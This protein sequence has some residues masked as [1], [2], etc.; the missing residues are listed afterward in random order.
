MRYFCILLLGL[1]STSITKTFAAPSVHALFSRKVEEKADEAG[2]AT[3]NLNKNNNNSIIVTPSINATIL[4]HKG[5]DITSSFQ[6]RIYSP[7][8]LPA[9]N[10][11]TNTTTNNN[12]LSPRNN[13]NYHHHHTRQLPTS[14]PLTTCPPGSTFY[15]S[16]CNP[17]NAHPGSLQAYTIICHSVVPQRDPLTGQP[18]TGGGFIPPQTIASR[19]RDGHCHDDEIC[20]PGLGAGRSRFGRRVATCVRRGLF[21]ELV[22]WSAG[23]GGE[24]SKVGEGVGEGG[25]VVEAGEQGGFGDAVQASMVMSRTDESTPVEVAGFEVDAVETTAEA[26][27]K[28]GVVRKTSRCRDCLELETKRLGPGVEAL[29]VQTTLLTTGAVAGVLWLAVVSG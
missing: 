18:L 9:N 7:D 15:E 22:S 25:G 17:T 1:I 23:G 8:S 10:T 27:G 24:R 11:N 20:V 3:S 26:D 28:N 13:P 6:I 29:K 4:D 12:S 2:K 19:R 16:Y 5:H 14:R 21:V